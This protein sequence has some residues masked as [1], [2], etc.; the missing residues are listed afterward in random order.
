ME[1][2]LE[3]KEVVYTTKP[4]SVV[5]CAAAAGKTHCLTERIRWL[6]EE[7][8]INPS[9]IVAITFTNLAADNILRRLKNPKGIHISTV[10]SYASYLLKCCGY[11]VSEAVENEDFD[12]LF[13]MVR[14]HP[15]CI[16][17]VQYLFLD[18]AQDSTAEQFDFLIDMIKP[19]NFMLIGDLR[20]TIYQFNGSRPDMLLRIMQQP[21]VS[22]FKLTQNYRNA[23][24]I[25]SFAKQVI[26]Q[27]GFDYRDD[28]R[29]MTENSGTV[30]FINWS[31]FLNLSQQIKKKQ[32]YKSWFI[33]CR[34]NRQV[35]EMQALLNIQGIPNDTFKMKNMTVAHLNELMVKNSI[36]VL[37]IHSAKGLEADNVVIYGA[38]NKWNS[39][40]IFV[41]YV[42][43]TRAKKNLFWVSKRRG[44]AKK[45]QEW[46]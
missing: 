35:E 21:D 32:D 34:S 15:D 7:R 44:A 2:S 37:T 27:K 14:L 40:E 12:K 31:S 3:Q 42:A 24:Q 46:D 23:Q 4:Y 30:Q 9:Q 11:D 25:L 10:H 5:L 1:L 16:Q 38:I 26:A 8:H 18:E 20:Q 45:I 33:L 36:K 29:A 39:D 19:K 13:E 22:V 17:P 41:N 43:I 6:I 28:S